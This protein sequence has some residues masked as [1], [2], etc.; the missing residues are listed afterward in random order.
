MIQKW[1]AEYELN[2]FQR[3]VGIPGFI[4]KVIIFHNYFF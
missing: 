4:F 2:A 3:G 1:T